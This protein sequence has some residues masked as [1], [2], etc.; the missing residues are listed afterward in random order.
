MRNDARPMGGDAHE[1]SPIDRH[2][3]SVDPRDS[4]KHDRHSPA[5][6]QDAERD[7]H[8][9]DHDIEPTMPTNNSTLRTKI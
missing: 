7:A 2:Q 1:Q 5:V 6:N 8:R 4:V 3:N 9:D